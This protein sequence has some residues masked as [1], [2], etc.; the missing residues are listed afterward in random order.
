MHGYYLARL[1]HI[2]SRFQVPVTV[3]H[4]DC[5]RRNSLGIR[6]H[7]WPC[8]DLRIKW[9][10]PTGQRIAEDEEKRMFATG[11]RR[12]YLENCSI[13]V[14]TRDGFHRVA[15]FVHVEQSLSGCFTFDFGI[16]RLESEN[17][18]TRPRC[19]TDR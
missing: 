6:P 15:L 16:G 19:W 18:R 5:T 8:V 11:Q 3:G 2:N 7:V 14:R 13:A 1:V 4:Y 10:S 9:I 17:S 12:L